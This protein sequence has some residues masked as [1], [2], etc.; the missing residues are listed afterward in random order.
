[1]HEAAEPSHS[2]TLEEPVEIT[3][4]AATDYLVERTIAARTLRAVAEDLLRAGDAPTTR[5]EI[6]A[7]LRQRAHVVTH[8]D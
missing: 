5:A 2:T 1:M 4:V 3:E 7:W 6:A 8:D